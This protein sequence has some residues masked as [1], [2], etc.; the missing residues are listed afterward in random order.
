MDPLKTLGLMLIAAM[1][2]MVIP[3]QAIVN[4]RL[5]QTLA[6]PFFAALVSFLG[7]TLAL[8]VLVLVT[9]P[10]IPAWP[11][12]TPVPWYL[13]TGGLYGVVFVTVV[14]VLVPRI[15]TV[16]VLAAGIAGQ[17]IMSIIV[18]HFGI[19]GVPHLPITLPRMIGCLT[20]L[21]SLFL[22]QMK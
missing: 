12:E 3:F 1:A 16:N 19:L 6:N 7:G 2:S 21:G 4:A 9:T 18:D 10:G 15:G 13:M 22:I 17:L 11:K 14:L 20:L 5:G 8:I